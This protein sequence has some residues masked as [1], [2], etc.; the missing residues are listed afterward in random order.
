M[1]NN[2]TTFVISCPRKQNINHHNL[3]FIENLGVITSTNFLGPSYH[4]KEDKQS[5]NEKST[6]TSNYSSNDGILVA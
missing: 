1:K 5:Y 6:S 2:V 3:N 4:Y